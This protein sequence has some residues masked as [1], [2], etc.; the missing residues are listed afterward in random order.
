MALINLA[1]NPREVAPAGS[2]GQLPVSDAMGH[3]VVI[4][5]SEFKENR[6]GTGEFVAFTLEIIEG[7]GVGTTG[8]WNLHLFNTNDKARDIAYSQL[9]ALCHVTGIFPEGADVDTSIWHGIPFRAV[10]C[11]QTKQEADTSYTEVK[12]LLH[13]DGSKPGK[14]QAVEAESAPEPPAKPAPG[15]AKPA[16]TKPA[17]FVK[18]PKPEAKAPWRP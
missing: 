6:K 8:N 15:P 7:D 1:L 2:G 14:G 12:R 17:G 5:D 13:A 3:L 4:T 9:S 10:V 18:P 16:M 11:L